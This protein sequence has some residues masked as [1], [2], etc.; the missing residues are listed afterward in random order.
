M[1]TLPLNLNFQA[2]DRRRPYPHSP[3][4]FRGGGRKMKER[5]P[6]LALGRRE[7]AKRRWKGL[8][9][10]PRVAKE[11]PRLAGRGGGLG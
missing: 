7:E 10:P 4:G 11:S 3:E 8:S 6:S 1:G 9:D 5:V 2:G